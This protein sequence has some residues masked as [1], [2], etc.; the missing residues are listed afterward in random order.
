[1]SDALPEGGRTMMTEGIRMYRVLGRT[2][3]AFALLFS[4]A[5]GSAKDGAKPKKPK[6]D[7]RAAPRMAVSP[8]QVLFTAE[9][10]GGDD[11][12]EYHCPE[13]EW[14]WDDGGKSVHESDCAPFETGTEIERR[15]TAEHVFSRQGTYN[16][17][18][19]MR[20]ADRVVAAARVTV[21]VRPGFGDVSDME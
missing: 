12:E 18:V 1:M 13:V 2:L 21:T 16:V 9:L 6:L 8:A 19:T 20:R 3:L 4:P 11:L 15:Y 7:V 17:K 14:D 10:A 5:L